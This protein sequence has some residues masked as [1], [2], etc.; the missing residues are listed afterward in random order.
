M[1]GRVDQSLPVGNEGAGVVVAAGAAAP[2]RHSSERRSP[3]WAARCTRSTAA[4]RRRSACHCRRA[5]PRPTG[6]ACF[7]NPLTALGMVETMRREGHT[8]LV[9]TAAASNLGA[10]AEPG[11]PQGWDRSRQHRAFRAAGQVLRAGGA[12]HRVQLERA[13]VSAGPHCRDRRD[14]RDAGLRCDRWRPLAGQ[15]LGCMEAALLAVWGRVPAL[16]LH[17]PQAG[18]HLRDARHRPDHCSSATSGPRGASAAG[19]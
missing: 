7:V 14:R 15:I 12:K 1:A 5:R 19:C 4:S 13:D 10:D 2:A 9:H 16:R 3:C 6:A 18:L 11:V 8:A 17:H